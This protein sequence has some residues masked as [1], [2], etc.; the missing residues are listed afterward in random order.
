[1]VNV[2]ESALFRALHETHPIC[3]IDEVDKHFVDP[4]SPIM[5]ILN[6][7]YKRG[8]SVMRC[9]GN[10]HAVVAF[11]VYSPKAFAGVGMKMDATTASRSIHIH[12]TRQD[13]GHRKAPLISW[14]LPA[15][16]AP[17]KAF[18]TKWGKDTEEA[19][20]T[21][22]P[23]IPEEIDDG[24]KIELATPLVVVGDQA[25]PDW[26]ERVRAGIIEALSQEDEA[27]EGVKIL[28]SIKAVFETLEEPRV[29]S[30][31]MIDRLIKIE[32]AN[33]PWSMMWEK[34]VRNGQTLKPRNQLAKMLKPYGIHPRNVRLS[35]GS[36]RKGYDIGQF[37]SAFNRYLPKKTETVNMELF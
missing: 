17:I 12:M 22:V 25:G 35:D 8:S 30:E 24:R 10:S 4:D 26:S 11:D 36:Q 21:V 7:G 34:D 37:T 18:L 6:G 31:E 28:A 13:S 9:V 15:E 5:G 19:L 20:K 23:A 2:S 16:V 1:M 32:D 27:T 33:A 3:F 14:N 29:S